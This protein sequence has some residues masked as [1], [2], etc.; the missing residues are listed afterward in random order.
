LL[1]YQ[2]TPQWATGL[3]IYHQ[4]QVKWRDGNFIDEY[5]RL[6]SHVTFRFALGRNSGKLQLVA[7]NITEDY[8][9]FNEENIFGSRYFISFSLDL[10]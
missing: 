7:Q 3:T 9:E 1:N 5:T 6:D 8:S 10:P 4:D 2:W